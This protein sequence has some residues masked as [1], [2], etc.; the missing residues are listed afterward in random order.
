MQDKEKLTDSE[1]KQFEQF[2]LSL[3]AVIS[4]KY[5]ATLQELKVRQIILILQLYPASQITGNVVLKTAWILRVPPKTYSA[6]RFDYLTQI[7]D[8]GV[9]IGR[10]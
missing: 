10:R 6:G 1:R 9:G 4:N 8:E 5:S 2:A 7:D 3:D